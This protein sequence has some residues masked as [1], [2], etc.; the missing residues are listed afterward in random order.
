MKK[1]TTKQNGNTVLLT[2]LLDSDLGEAGTERTFWMPS[3][4]GYVHEISDGRPGTL[5]QQVCQRLSGSGSC[6]YLSDRAFL[7]SLV[8][9]E[10][11]AC[12]REE[13]AE[14]R[15]WQQGR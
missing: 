6:L 15:R 2:C 3:E 8:R 1:Y 9:R 12:L 5:G 13:L 4:R 7:L 10:A 11:A 14:A